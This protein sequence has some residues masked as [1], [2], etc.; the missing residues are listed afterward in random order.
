[1]NSISKQQANKIGSKLGKRLQ[2]LVLSRPVTLME[3]C[4][5]HT[6]VLFRSGIKYLLP[7][8]VKLL[9]GPGCPVCVTPPGYVDLA[10]EL[11]GRREIIIATFGDMVRVPGSKGSLRQS[12]AEG[13][14]IRV[15]YSPLEAIALARENPLKKVVF[16]AVGFE[17]TAPAVAATVLR[18][19]AEGISN[20]A[21]LTAHKVVSKALRA[22]LADPEI[23]LDGFILPGHV[24]AVTGSG[25]F[26]FIPEE[27]KTP[28]IVAG[29]EPVQMLA[30][31]LK[32]V[33]LALKRQPVLENIY[34]EVVSKQGNLQAQAFL[35]RVFTLE[36]SLWR[37]IGVIPG[38][39]LALKPELAGYDARKVYGL[40]ENQNAGQAACQCGEI[41]KG[42]KN[43]PDCPLFKTACSP[44]KPAGPCMVS[45]EG[46]C[47]AYFKYNY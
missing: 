18:A 46:A 7:P 3:V 30:A 6:H 39:G 21:F 15:I 20:L 43:P 12:G 8:D 41:L 24:C 42:K 35:G 32:L 22:L 10:M 37:G 9:S 45:S 16:L 25:I 36:D 17:A 28:A 1:M 27:C 38:S 11:A 47:G 31:I 14:D 13:A 5:T 34:T 29:F 2:R 4:G 33:P 19:A 26:N 40:T 44:E 23:L